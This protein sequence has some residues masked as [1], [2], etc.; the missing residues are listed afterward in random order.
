[1]NIIKLPI[2]FSRISRLQRKFLDE[3]M[4]YTGLIGAQY[5]IIFKLYENIT[6]T[7]KEISELGIIE[8][9]TIA[10][11]LKKLEEMNYIKKITSSQDRRSY[12]V[13][14]TSLGEVIALE[15]DNNINLL[16]KNYQEVLDKNTMEKLNQI[17]LSLEK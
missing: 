8:K 11:N 10:K 9:A 6:M 15:I 1:M 13:S 3:K 7:P 17:L 5:L 14:L 16:D 12:S 2:L 4:K